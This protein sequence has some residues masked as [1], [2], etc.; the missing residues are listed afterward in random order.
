MCIRISILACCLTLALY[1]EL[2]AADYVLSFELRE[3]RGRQ[4]NETVAPVFGAKLVHVDRIW[5]ALKKLDYSTLAQVE[6]KVAP[7]AKY[8]QRTRLGGQTLDVKIRTGDLGDGRES[9][10]IKLRY[11][12]DRQASDVED[13]RYY[14]VSNRP[15][16]LQSEVAQLGHG[17][18]EV[19]LLWVATLKTVETAG[20]QNGAANAASPLA[21]SVTSA[22]QRANAEGFN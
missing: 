12:D 4:A 21:P 9:S 13:S 14:G 17:Q 10:A 7:H 20:R 1:S 5:E 3:Y 19:T 8:E 18:T 6:V 22:V 2:Y 15:F 16:F 11:R